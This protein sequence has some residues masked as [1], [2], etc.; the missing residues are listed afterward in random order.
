MRTAA[1]PRGLAFLPL[2]N[3]LLRRLFRLRAAEPL[4]FTLVARRIYILP[5]RQGLAFGLL[6]AGMLLG[7]LNYGLSMGFLFTFLLT[8]LL[9]STLFATWRVLLGATLERIETEAGFA[10]DQVGFRLSLRLPEGRNGTDIRLQA[11]DGLQAGFTPGQPAQAEAWLRAPARRRGVQPLGPCRVYSEAPLGLFRAWAVFAPTAAALV[12]P[13][14]AS[15]GFPL[16]AAAGRENDRPTGSQRGA[17]DFDGLAGYAPGESPSRLAWKTLG[18]HPDP[19]VKRFI[20]PQGGALWLDW[21]DLPGLEP[22]A[23]LSH[24]ARWVQDADLRGL[25]YGLRLAGA[26]IPPGS[27][28]TQRLLCLNALALHGQRGDETRDGP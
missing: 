14:P 26:R 1:A 21:D 4:P 22:E 23:R 28:A 27:G 20:A 16:P 18:R 15:R 17:E 11:T 24:L 5:T 10:G 12:W 9:L 2:R 19:L 3:G 8:G 25:T 6:L 7:S 13:K